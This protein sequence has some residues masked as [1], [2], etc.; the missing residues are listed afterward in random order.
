MGIA[1]T[2]I[3]HTIAE[4]FDLE[5]ASEVRHEFDNG[6]ITEMAGGILP[7]NVLKGEVY[8]N[9]NIAI[10]SAKMPNMALNSDTKVRIESANRFV[11]PDITISDG[12]PEY[13]TT[14]EGVVRRD[15]IINP[16][17][18]VEVLS[19]NTRDYDKGGKFDLY[20]TIPG[21]REYIL[22]EPETC[23]VKSMY[24]KDP[25]NGLWKREVLTDRGA[26]LT[27]HSLQ[28]SLPI[29]EFYAAVE[30]LAE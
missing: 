9:I 6:T 28:L 7:H 25:A 18:I 27:L 16:L 29:E 11:Y 12:K 21:F 10:R 22:I 24:L 4:Y 2:T 5:D 14:P 26:S 17:L 1:T 19:E 8:T 3:Y 30:R 23:W 13:Y 20:C 15:T